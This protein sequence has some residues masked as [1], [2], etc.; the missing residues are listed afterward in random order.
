MDCANDG[1]NNGIE[2]SFVICES[3][4]KIHISGRSNGNLNVQIILEKFGGGGHMMIA[5]AQIEGKSIDEVKAMLI[6]AINEA[7]N[8]KE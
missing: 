3:D 7:I 5:G 8:K 1:V 6:D 4:N 2:S